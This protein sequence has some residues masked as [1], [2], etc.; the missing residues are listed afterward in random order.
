M[1]FK[2]KREKAEEV[3]ENYARS[4]AGTAFVAGQLEGQFALVPKL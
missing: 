2:E 1:N 3:I 4:H